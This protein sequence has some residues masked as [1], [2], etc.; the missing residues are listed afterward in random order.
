MGTYPRYAK[1]PDWFDVLDGRGRE[2]FVTRGEGKMT[3]VVDATDEARLATE[4]LKSEKRRT[5]R[6][7]E[8]NI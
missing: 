5:Q 1:L 4:I 6:C 7:V 8:W 3:L 2:L